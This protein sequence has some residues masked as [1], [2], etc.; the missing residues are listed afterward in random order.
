MRTREPVAWIAD[1]DRGQQWGDG[2]R[3]FQPARDAPHEAALAKVDAS[4]AR[5]QLGWAPRLRLD[6]ALAWTV[7]WHRRLAAGASATLALTDEQIARY[8]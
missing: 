4:R 3:W 8:G 5:S 7:E 6:E 2:A 1:R